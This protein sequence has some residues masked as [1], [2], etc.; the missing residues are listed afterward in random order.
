MNTRDVPHGAVAMIPYCSTALKRDRRMH[1]YRPRATRPSAIAFPYLPAAWRERFR[2]RLVHRRRAGFIIDNLIAAKKV[3]PMIVVM[4]T[5][6]QS[7]AGG[8][9]WRHEP[10]RAECD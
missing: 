8:R 2:R 7:T 6:S 9:G 10:R 4:P 1:V 3:K 5:A